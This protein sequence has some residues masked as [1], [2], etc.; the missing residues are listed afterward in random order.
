MRI[1]NLIVSFGYGGFNRLLILLQNL[2]LAFDS[3]DFLVLILTLYHQLVILV[4]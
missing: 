2:V 3:L 1:S 4:P